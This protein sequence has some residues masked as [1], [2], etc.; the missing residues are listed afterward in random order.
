[1]KGGIY[2]KL[3]NRINENSGFRTTDSGKLPP[4]I[5]HKYLH[6]SARTSTP[7]TDDVNNTDYP[8]TLAPV[9]CRGGGRGCVCVCW[10]GYIPHHIPPCYISLFVPLCVPFCYILLYTPLLLSTFSHST[11]L[12]FALSSICYLHFT[13]CHVM[14]PF[15]FHPVTF[16]FMFHPRTF[17]CTFLSVLLHYMFHPVLFFSTTLY[18]VYF[19]TFY[20][21]PSHVLPRDVSTLTLALTGPHLSCI[22]LLWNLWNGM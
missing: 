3:I 9:G 15:M 7:E 22:F 17:H 5:R 19:L 4:N 11:L 13:S 21:P 8:D 1:M 20:V 12:C 6:Q 10:G 18:P 14:F 16:P 2:L